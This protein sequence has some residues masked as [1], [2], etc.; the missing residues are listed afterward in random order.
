[1]RL[2]ARQARVHLHVRDRRGLDLR[3]AP[4]AATR[5]PGGGEPRILIPADKKGIWHSDA[6]LAP[7]GQGI[8]YIVFDRAQY[9][10]EGMCSIWT[11]EVEGG[12]PRHLTNGGEYVL[13]W[14]PDGKW[15]AYE[16]RIKDM[17]FELYK[18]PADGGEPVRMNIRGRSPGFSPDGRKI[19]FS[20]RLEAGYE[21][22]LAENVLPARGG[23]AK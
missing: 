20:R 15:I 5:P 3:P 1:M 2:E 6:R 4:R 9:T 8:A 11:M 22:W 19:A 7:N 10:K 21:Y 23:K 13:C 18:I 17:D 12:T 14:S 16:K